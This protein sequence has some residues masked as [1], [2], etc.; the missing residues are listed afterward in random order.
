MKK[1]FSTIIYSPSGLIHYLR[2]PFAS[3]LYRYELENPGALTPDEETEEEKLF[4]TAGGRARVFD[5][6]K[7]QDFGNEY[8]RA[9]C[10]CGIRGFLKTRSSRKVS[11]LGY[12][13]GEIAQALLC[14]PALL[15]FRNAGCR[16]RERPPALRKDQAEPQRAAQTIGVYAADPRETCRHLLPNSSGKTGSRTSRR[17]AWKKIFLSIRG[18]VAPGRMIATRTW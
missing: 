9:R 4:S 8:R 11:G 16:H 18:Y 13:T 10:V 1:E 2:S 15:L 7:L 12:E 14:D 5:P 6:L 17:L 3:W